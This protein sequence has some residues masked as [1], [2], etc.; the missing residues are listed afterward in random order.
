[1]RW[2]LAALTLLALGCSKGGDSVP[3]TAPVAAVDRQAAYEERLEAERGKRG[4]SDKTQFEQQFGRDKTATITITGLT[5][6]AAALDYY[7]NRKLFKAA[8]ADYD[9]AAKRAQAQNEANKQAAEQKA[10]QEHKQQWG[11][12]GPGMIWYRYQPVKCDLPYPTIKKGT[13]AEGTFVYYVAPVLNLDE[14]SRRFDIGRVTQIDQAGRSLQLQSLL[15]DPVPD[16]DLEEL[17]INHGK[18]SV[19]KIVVTGATQE[20]E[21]VSYF[22]EKQAVR[23][24]PSTT[25]ELVG[26]KMSKVGEFEMSVGPATDLNALANRIDF[27]KVT[28][29]DPATR[30]ITVQAALPADLPPRPTPEELHA[31][32][33]KAWDKPSDMDT[34][35]RGD[36]DEVTWVLRILKGKHV[37]A[38]DA[39]H[40]RLK[41]MK[42]SDEDKAKIVEALIATLG[43]TPRLEAH[44]DSMRQFQT[45]EVEKAIID[46]L[47]VKR[48]F[49]SENDV[50]Y[51]HLKS[52]KFTE[53]NQK[54]LEETIVNNVPK[55]P[56]YS[57]Q[58]FDLMLAHR[59]KAVDR[60]LINM[61]GDSSHSHAPVIKAVAKLGTTEAA[62]GLIGRLGNFFD[63][64]EARQALVTMGP[65]AE[66]AVLKLVDNPSVEVRVVAYGL[67]T[68]VGTEKS[69]TKLKAQQTKDRD[70]N[71]KPAAKQA[72]ELLKSRLDDE[73][74]EGG[75][76]ADAKGS[77]DEESKRGKNETKGK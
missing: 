9:A 43:D 23:L 27:G 1:M 52:I 53:E 76:A 47:N 34:K 28:N 48:T 3:T 73:K 39:V 31:E 66:D 45:P 57:D 64:D 58:Y 54:Y 5:G 19:A 70:R 51:R 16:I 21:R 13:R 18:D 6:D 38:V 30:T 17:L 74:A 68:Q 61:L 44:L 41:G 75:D 24:H 33:M 4:L 15:P 67:L 20:K 49:S 40:A 14:F 8:W 11:D 55:G 32:R 12:F 60:A 2:P 37:F 7:I 29:V 72:Y 26:P 10:V 35:P 63:K 42:P 71:G 59:S 56:F 65:K 25:L 22:L 36:E 69:L 77:K 50:V 62:M 46:L